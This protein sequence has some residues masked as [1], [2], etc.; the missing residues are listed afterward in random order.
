MD[1]LLL[2]FEVLLITGTAP[3]IILGSLLLSG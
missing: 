2:I 1:T 3:A